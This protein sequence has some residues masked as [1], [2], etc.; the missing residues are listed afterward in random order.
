MLIGI[1]PGSAG[2]I[3]WMTAKMIAGAVKMPE[4]EADVVDLLRDLGQQAKFQGE[5]TITLL[6]KVSGYVGGAGATFMP[7][8][9]CSRPVPVKSGGQPGSAMFTFG[10]G[11][12]LLRGAL[13]A[14]KMPF[15]DVTP[16]TWQKVHGLGTSKG[17]TKTEW[18]NK[19]KA[20]AQQLY[21]NL[22]VTLSTA[23]ALLILSAARIRYPEIT[24]RER[25]R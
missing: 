20:R 16:Q 21:P 1:D 2:G 5:E 7:C 17:M 18:K 15:D 6:E 12:G 14:L 19:L 8:P 23:D 13:L 10:T 11:Y 25:G 24:H 4:T 3:A 9:H 22:N